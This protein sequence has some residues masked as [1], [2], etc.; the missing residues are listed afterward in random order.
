MTDAPDPRAAGDRPSADERRVRTGLRALVDEMMAQLRSAA[1]ADAWTEEDRARAEA[2]L[3]R[4]MAQVR[5]ETFRGR[6][7]D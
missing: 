7:D 2:D 6:D 4:I 5:D 1:A 3:A